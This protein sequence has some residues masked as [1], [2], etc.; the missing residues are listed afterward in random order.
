MSASTAQVWECDHCSTIY[1]SPVPL[2][3]APIHHCPSPRAR[4]VRDFKLRPVV[5]ETGKESAA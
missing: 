1:K 3:F 2:T 4:K 5:I